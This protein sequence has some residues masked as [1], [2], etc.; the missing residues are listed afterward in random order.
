MGSPLHDGV[1]E[2]R[3]VWAKNA[4]IDRYLSSSRVVNN[5]PPSVIHT[6]LPDRG[7]LVALIAGKR[8]RLLI[9]G[10]VDEVFMTRRLNLNTPKSAEQNI[11]YAVVNLK[12][13]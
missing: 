11:L 5:R 12:P 6:A 1:F 4:I 7:N 2:C 13:Q 3:K 9:A 10:T 8:R